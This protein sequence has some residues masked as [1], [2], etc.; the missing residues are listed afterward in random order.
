VQLFHPESKF[1][2]AIT[3]MA[4]IVILNM[5]FVVSCLPILTVGAATRAANVVVRDMVE[6]VGSGHAMQFLR[7]LT[8]EWKAATAYWLLLAAAFALL[9]Y[10]QWVVFRAGV[11][12]VA[13]TIIQALSISGAFV[14]AAITVWF[15]GWASARSRPSASF[16][17]LFNAAVVSTF[18]RLGRTVVAVAIASA[19]VFL[20]L[21]LPFGWAVPLTFFFIPAMTI[22][23]IRLVIAEGLGERLG[24]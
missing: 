11:Q 15:Y 17:A 3:L 20:I 13:L 22:Y 24:E 12:G 1:M 10:Q 8:N 5:L 4:D 14:I 16:V 18:T 19:G 7:E 6:G 21:W 2:S 9:A 23:L